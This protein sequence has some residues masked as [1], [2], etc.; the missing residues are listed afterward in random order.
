[1]FSSSFYLSFTQSIIFS[2]NPQSKPHVNQGGGYGT[3][4]NIYRSLNETPVN[5]SIIA[6]G[7]T[8]QDG[9]PGIPLHQTP[10]YTPGVA[11]PT[12][13]V[14]DVVEDLGFGMYQVIVSSILNLSPPPKFTF[15][16]ALQFI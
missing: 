15:K 1:M 12:L 5:N 2:S 3:S 4:G 8:P 14:D 16:G 6:N 7:G 11:V 9:S 13:S 10:S